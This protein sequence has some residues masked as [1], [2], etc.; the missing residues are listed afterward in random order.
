[1]LFIARNC[2]CR[3][4]MLGAGSASCAAVVTALGTRWWVDPLVASL[5][6]ALWVWGWW[7][8]EG[9]TPRPGRPPHITSALIAYWVGVY[10]WTCVVEP[11]RGVGHGCPTNARSAAYLALE[12]ASGVVS[13]DFLFF[14]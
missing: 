11:P 7:I 13:Y 6:F 14:W 5:S 12:V 10:A 3:P 4:E 2:R 8:A 1:V 9:Y